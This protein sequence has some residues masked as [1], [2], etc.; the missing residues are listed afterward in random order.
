MSGSI[1]TLFTLPDLPAEFWIK[2]VGDVAVFRG[3]LLFTEFDLNV[4]ISLQ[5]TKG[6]ITLR[7]HEKQKNT[8]LNKVI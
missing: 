7:T 1:T 5:T 2:A 4:W 6:E 8:T 3:D